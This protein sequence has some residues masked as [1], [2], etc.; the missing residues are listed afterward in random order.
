MLVRKYNNEFTIKSHHIVLPS[1]FLLSCDVG[2]FFNPPALYG[3]FPIITSNN[4]GDDD[5][6]DDDGDDGDGSVGDED[7]DKIWSIAEISKKLHSKIF[8]VTPS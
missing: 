1:F 5:D 4:T 8:G 3:G 2:T 6:D 7:D